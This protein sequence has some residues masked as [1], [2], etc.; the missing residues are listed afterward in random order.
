MLN[1]LF[2]KTPLFF[3]IQSFWRDEAFSYLMAK[4]NIKEIIFFTAK[5]F[6][7]PLYY[8]LLHFWI[9][10]FGSSEIMIRSLSLIFYC[11]SIYVFFL[12]FIEILKIKDW[13]LIVLF[14]IFAI[15]N[16]LLIYYAFEGRMYSM[17]V[18]F[19]TLSCYSFLKNMKKTYLLSTILNLF[20]HYFAIFIYLSQ[21]LFFIKKRKI[22]S[23]NTTYIYF[24]PFLFFLPWLFFLIWVKKN[25]FIDNFWITKLDLYKI[26]LIFGYLYTGFEED[27]NFFKNEIVYF[28]FF[29][30]FLAVFLLIK[31]HKLIF[32][33]KYLHFFLIWGILMPIFIFLISL[34]KPI[35]LPRYLIPFS[36][37]FLLFLV[38]NLILIEKKAT[39]FLLI[40][41]IIFNYQYNLKQVENRKK[42][43]IRKIIREIKFLASKNDYLYVVDVL[44]FHPAQYYFG[45]E[46]V[47]IYDIDYEVI[48]NYVGKVLI[49]KK[50]I[51]Y[52]FPLYPNKAFVLFPDG[53]YEI[54]GEL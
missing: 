4:K 5:D 29:I 18:F 54:R 24:L 13:Y 2:Y 26:F 45:E 44:D 30:F 47:F 17:Y 27:F 36:V 1:F 11:L 40:L 6:N 41:L 9:K 50:N 43:D 21:I 16:P 33:K 34:F 37:G 12:F 10:L 7:P 38:S 20:T 42:S 51:K 22:I 23:K 52:K 48:P 49:D 53:H 28:G 31:N 25:F 35:F 32:K 3:M 15:T 14:L 19:S 46:N 8:L 39:F